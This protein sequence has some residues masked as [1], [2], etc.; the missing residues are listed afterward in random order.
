MEIGIILMNCSSVKLEE[1]GVMAALWRG[2]NNSLPGESKIVKCGQASDFEA[3]AILI[4]TSETG[5]RRLNQLQRTG[6][7]DN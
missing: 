1:N 5:D 7:T 6:S 3:T 2:S 4:R